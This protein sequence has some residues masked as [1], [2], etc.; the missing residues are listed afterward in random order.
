MTGRKNIHALLH[1]NTAT[2][3]FNRHV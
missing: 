3:Y 1:Q 2:F